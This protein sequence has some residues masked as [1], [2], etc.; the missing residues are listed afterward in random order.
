MMFILF[1]FPA[2]GVTYALYAMVSQHP[3]ICFLMILSMDIFGLAFLMFSY[4]KELNIDLGDR[5]APTSAPKSAW[6]LKKASLRERKV[7]VKRRNSSFTWG[8]KLKQEEREHG[9][10]VVQDI[11]DTEESR[12]RGHLGLK[13]KQA[14]LREGDVIVSVEGEALED[15][16]FQDSIDKLQLKNTVRISFFVLACDMFS[17]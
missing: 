8:I 6:E 15:L 7:K 13:L 17:L 1:V 12:K 14:G 10:L 3:I 5:K 16:D 4:R 11:I 9:N 2:C